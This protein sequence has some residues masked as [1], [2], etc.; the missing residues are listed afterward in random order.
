M[1]DHPTRLKSKLSSMAFKDLPSVIPP[2][3]D[4]SLESADLVN[5][6]TG[7]PVKCES[8]INNKNVFSVSM[9]RAIFGT[10]LC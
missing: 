3:L 1:Q 10:Y 7:C 4:P 2:A 9:S 5:K 8:Q 6:S